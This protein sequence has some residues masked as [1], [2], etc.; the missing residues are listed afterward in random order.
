MAGIKRKSPTVSQSL[1][2]KSKKLKVEKSAKKAPPKEDSEDLIES[3]TSEDEHG[4]FGFAAKKGSTAD[5]SEDESSDSDEQGEKTRRAIQKNAESRKDPGQ[6]QPS[7]LANLNATSSREA[8]A[9]QKALAKERKAAKPN[10]NEVER[11]KKLW[12]KLRL[13]SHVEK[14]ERKT[15]VKE[16]FEIITG[17]VK[18]F[19]FKHDSVRVIQCA[20]KYSTIEQRRTIARELKD[21]FKTLA[22]GKYSKFLIAKLLEKGDPEIR[23]LIISEFYGHVRRLINHPEAAWILD[24]TYRAVATSEQKNR[25]L[26]EWYGPEFSIK[27]LQ[28]QGTDSA[29]LSA[30]LNESPEKR[31]PILEYLESQIN[32]LVQKK[33]TGFTMLHDAML[34]YFLAC[35]PGSPEANDFLEH[36]RPDTT[37][38]EGEE[39]DNVDILKNLAFTKSGSRLVSLALAYGTAKDR[40]VFLKPYK[41][42]MEMMAYD[43]NAHHVLLAALAVVDDTKLTSKSIFGE[44]LP[45][46]DT[47]PEKVLNLASDPRARAVLLYPFASDAKWLMD[48][49]SRERLSEIYTIR[50]TTSKKDPNTRQQEIARS[51]E[52]QILTSITA[53]AKD[54]ASFGFGLQFLGE[55]LVGAPDVEPAKRQEALLEVV[56]LAQDILDSSLTSTPTAAEQSTDAVGAGPKQ[57]VS[58]LGK[59]MLKTLVQGGKYDPALKKVVRVEPDLG[60]A[61]LFWDQIKADVGRWATGPG[62]FVIVGLVE[63]EGFE[64]RDEVLKALGKEKKKLEAAAGPAKADGKAKKKGDKGGKG[65]KDGEGGRGNAGARILLS[66]L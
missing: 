47:L 21:E 14:E 36:L 16:L 45:A 28:S 34:Q 32:Q 31:K 52:P 29:E 53:R 13:K 23:D 22:E 7:A 37:L 6:Q 26:R 17:R 19:V 56:K 49:K 61:N 11:S 57:D 66:K 35:K 63:S 4:Y 1:S 38:K 33:L 3:D 59:N 41:D 40:K 12:E 9:K 60:F 18:D 50:S 2:N 5:S 27:G 65:K 51:I 44:L 20:I 39:S 64:R 42:T 8:H 62:S 46:N 58:A 10:A 43:A 15:L 55:V 30:I 24:D 54:F 25:L 48:D